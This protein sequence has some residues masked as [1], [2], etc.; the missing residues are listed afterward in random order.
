MSCSAT[1]FLEVRARVSLK[2]ATSDPVRGKKN[3]KKLA[4]LT[5]LF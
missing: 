4:F 3:P 1:Y 2:G 5:L